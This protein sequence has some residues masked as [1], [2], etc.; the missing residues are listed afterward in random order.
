MT[1]GMKYKP[2]N[3]RVRARLT[4]RV[5]E[6]RK[7]D[8]SPSLPAGVYLSFIT[9]IVLP[10][11]TPKPVSKVPHLVV[12]NIRCGLSEPEQRCSILLGCSELQLHLAK[13]RMQSVRD[14]CTAA[15]NRAIFLGRCG[16]NNGRAEKSRPRCFVFG[17]EWC[18]EDEDEANAVRTRSQVFGFVWLASK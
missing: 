17:E 18:A 15:Y 11:G 14:C 3:F 10:R 1:S 7:I 12:P 2:L 8:F 5:A 13:S 9:V 16:R 4:V 6:S